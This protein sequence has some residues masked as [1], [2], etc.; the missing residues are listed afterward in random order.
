[1]DSHRRRLRLP[2]AGLVLALP[3]L[4]CAA[5]ALPPAE[6]PAPGEPP[7]RVAFLVVDGVYGTELVAPYDVLEHA[8]R[9]AGSAVEIYTV[10]PDGGEVVTAE[11]LRIVPRH[12]F[13]DAP[14]ADVLVVPSAEGS[15]DADLADEAMIAW[16]AETGARS[17]H[18]LSLCWGAFVLARAG[19][20][21]G[22]AATTF[23]ADYARF[24]ETFP[25]VDVRVNV[26]FVHDREAITSQGGARSYEAA[27]YLAERLFGI[28]VARRVGEGLLISWPPHH[29][30]FLTTTDSTPP[31]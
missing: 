23:P 9:L 14:P 26:S 25:A 22:H 28:E 2:L 30:S 31:Q 13:A 7:L 12:G 6:A 27:L 15:R 24:A 4:A 17:R 8:G 3:A 29:A 21:D 16:V 20:L 10:S 19:L 1:M 11:G 5:A 18:V